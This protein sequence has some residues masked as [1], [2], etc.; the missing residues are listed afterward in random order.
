MWWEGP[1]NKGLNK[2]AHIS[3]DYEMPTNIRPSSGRAGTVYICDAC[4]NPS[5]H[6]CAKL[7]VHHQK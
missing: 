3:H 1:A 6:Y 4:N 7:T 2:I 5:L